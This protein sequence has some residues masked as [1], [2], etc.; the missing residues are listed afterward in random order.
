MES[1]FNYSI[2]INVVNSFV[3]LLIS[4]TK[5]GDKMGM[6]ICTILMD[7]IKI[8]VRITSKR[9]S[10]KDYVVVK[11]LFNMMSI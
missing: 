9:I 7:F 8:H 1:I 6:I 5:I 4:L 2:F 11:C 3:V 10:E